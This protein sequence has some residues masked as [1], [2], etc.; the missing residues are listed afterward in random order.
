MT[1]ATMAASKLSLVAGAA[2]ML[3]AFPALAQTNTQTGNMS[4]ASPAPSAAPGGAYNSN[5]GMAPRS[6][7]GSSAGGMHAYNQG[8]D[9]HHAMSPH[10]AMRSGRSDSSQN[11]A[12]DRLNE[13]SLQAA[14]QGQNFM[15]GSS[16]GG[17][18][19]PASDNMGQ[20]GMGQGGMGQGGG[21]S[22]PGTGMPSQN[23][24]K[25]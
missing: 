16:T 11:A 8:Q 25:M 23:G 6:N 14:Q 4:G 9:T 21:M 15:S 22:Q 1:Q 20:G 3:A 24:G 19:A 7:M 5:P 13:Q 10:H 2:L 17:S 12:V 18:A